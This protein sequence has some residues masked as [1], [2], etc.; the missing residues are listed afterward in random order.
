MRGTGGEAV[1]RMMLIH[2]GASFSTH[3]VY[4]G[5]KAGLEAHDVEVIEYR[6][7]QHL[8]LMSGLVEC[9]IEHER[10]STPVNPWILAASEAI[11]MAVHYE[12]DAVLVISG[13]NFHIARAAVLRELGAQRRKSMPAAIYCTESPYFDSEHRFAAAYDVVF[14]NE[15]QSVP[16]FVHNERVVYLPHAY[17]P[18]VHQP[19]PAEPEKQ[20]D[21]FFVGTG[22]PERRALFAG[23]DWSGISFVTRGFLW[24]DDEVAD[25]INPIGVTPN[26]EAAQWYRSAAI[27][28][29]H[30]RTT[31]AYGSGAHIAPA[32]AASLGP[33][34]YE[35]AACGGF[36]LCDDSRAELY[37]VFG[38]AVPMYRAGDSADLE[39]QIRSWLAHPG[40]REE[41]ARAQHEAVKPHTWAARAETI[42]ATLL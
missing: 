34:A 28:L 8:Q 23:V 6:L 20:C 10:L 25:A 37:D 29:N 33:R 3:D 27:C 30:H 19:G 24:R 14:T 5:V 21:V 2:P 11:G 15:R 17:N 12:P 1:T 13:G 32:S 38:D 40:R 16:Q 31:M 7:D 36:Q 22:F 26:E 9:A 39:R 4:T 35:I 18:R 42:L 41:H